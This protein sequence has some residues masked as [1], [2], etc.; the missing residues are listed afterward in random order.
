[1]SIKVF[2]AEESR[3]ATR[4]S[5]VL[6]VEKKKE[7]KAYKGTKFFN[8]FFNINTFKRKNGWFSAENIT[9]SRGVADPANIEDV[10][11]EFKGTRLQL[12]TT[13]KRAGAIGE[14][15]LAVHFEWLECVKHLAEQG[16]I[17]LAKRDVHNVVTTHRSLKAKEDPGAELDDPL[18]S[19]KVDF[20]KYPAKYPIAT[21]V[22]QP[23]TV[24]LDYDTAYMDGEIEKYREAK[25]DVDGQ[26]VP[27]AENNLHL[28]ANNG[29]EMKKLRINI[30][31]ASQSQG[32]VS[33][34]VLACRVVLKT[35]PPEGFSDD[36][37]SVQSPIRTTMPVIANPANPVNMTMPVGETA[38]V[39]I[40]TAASAAM[41][42]EEVLQNI[43]L[44]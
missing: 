22:G 19:F 1:M 27:V 41:T 16:I 43:G 17:D 25:V 28:F 30:A 32:W 3:D 8:V 31:S 5:K 2:T 12:Q 4:T 7:D 33:M 21:L 42:A 15:L 37:P 29:A 44:V 36:M 23:K 24:F 14:F 18:I 13:V 10:R 34:P 38:P 35:G 6:I 11:N 9:L 40:T 39:V 26:I 20:E